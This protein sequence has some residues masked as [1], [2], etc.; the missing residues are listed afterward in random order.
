[1]APLAGS[2]AAAAYIAD[3]TFAAEIPGPTVAIDPGEADRLPVAA[4]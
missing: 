2:P 4:P 3:P 1:M